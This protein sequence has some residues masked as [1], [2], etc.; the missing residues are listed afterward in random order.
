[1]SREPDVNLLSLHER[2]SYLSV[3]VLSDEKQTNA[4]GCDSVKT[5]RDV[6]NTNE[7]LQTLTNINVNKLFCFLFDKPSCLSVVLLHAA[8]FAQLTVKNFP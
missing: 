8:D 5:H 6:M 7:G 1:M 2:K 4:D 3:S